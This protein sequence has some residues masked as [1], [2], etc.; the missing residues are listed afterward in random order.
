[1]K[2][3]HPIDLYFHAF[4]ETRYAVTLRAHDGANA[5]G[6]LVL[7][8]RDSEYTRLAAR[9]SRD[10]LSREELLRLGSILYQTLFKRQFET[11]LS[12]T[13]AQLPPSESLRLRLHIDV[14]RTPELAAVPWE[15]LFV[16]T[17]R[18]P[19]VLNDIPIVRCIR[20]SAGVFGAIGRPMRVLLTA[21]AA[22][23]PPTAVER[24][25][26]VIKSALECLGEQVHLTIQP[27][28]TKELLLN[29]LREEIQIWHF[30]GHGGMSSDG[31][32]L[33]FE[34][35]A[36]PGDAEPI[37]AH[38][39]VAALS[40]NQPTLVVLDACD[41]GRVVHNNAVWSMAPALA[42][43]AVP[44]VVAMQLPMA[45][46]AARAFASEFYK[47]LAQGQIVEACVNAGRRAL[48]L[49]TRSLRTG[50]GIP[51]VYTR[52]EW[53]ERQTPTGINRPM[54][55]VARGFRSL[56]QLLSDPEV[57][58]TTSAVF[59]SRSSVRLATK[60]I[61]EL[62]EYKQLHDL[63]HEIQDS[64]NTIAVERERL[65]ND[66]RVWVDI[67]RREPDLHEQIGSALQ[68]MQAASVMRT[69]AARIASLDQCRALLRGA[70]QKRDQGQFDQAL[71][72]ISDVLE[73]EPYRINVAL[74]QRAGDLSLEDL[75]NELAQILQRR[76]QLSLDA[77]SSRLFDEFRIGL[78][79]L[80]R[81]G[82]DLAEL[83][84]D[85]DQFQQI[86]HEL[87]RVTAEMKSDQALFV[88]FWRK[89]LQATSKKLCEGRSTNWADDLRKCIDAL[90]GALE[91]GDAYTITV[92]SERY[93]SQVDQIFNRTDK[94]IYDICPRLTQIGREIDRL[95]EQLTR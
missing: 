88:V 60:Q 43:G 91:D 9:L 30:V 22:V 69:R 38:W 47:E 84:E 46:E 66:P 65:L 14:E 51:V 82:K 19:L 68:V 11:I 52:G 12:N 55:P 54:D 25:F 28:L 17:D 39:L 35:T 41:S 89:S 18:L 13:R 37:P 33:L 42:Y 64:F 23:Q 27:H 53:D 95:L 72:G 75:T 2:T 58:A 67:A 56:G 59:N 4:D 1:M 74:V 21:A 61:S 40:A 32:Q 20:Q 7:P 36:S 71:E 50:W 15:F 90:D 29:Y 34:D 45:D 5:T 86:D 62:T 87:R 10:D 73:S 94:D 63:L 44:A 76:P 6:E 85:H 81:L 49:H 80:T 16:P 3:Y 24:E 70:T 92:M 93:R 79:E 77:N 78:D 31:G 8:P 26:A 57:Y 48:V 83:I